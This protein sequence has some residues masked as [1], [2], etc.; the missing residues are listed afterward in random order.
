M[1]PW[2]ARPTAAAFFFA[3]GVA[4]VSVS[5]GDSAQSE[6]RYRLRVK[7]VDPQ[8]QGNSAVAIDFSGDGLLDIVCG[9]TGYLAPD[10]QKVSLYEVAWIGGRLDDYASL[11]YDVNGDGRTDLI[12]ANY[13]S[14]SIEW[15]EQADPL[16][17]EWRRHRV[18]SPGAMETGRLEDVDGDGRLDLVP[19]GRDFAAWWEIVADQVGSVRWLRHDWPTEA[20]GHGIGL[21]DINGDGRRDLVCPRGWFE[22]PADRRSGRWR[23]H[24]D[25]T[26]DADASI[27]ILVVDVDGD[28]DQDLIW[29]RGHAVGI[30]WLEQVQ[31]VEGSRVWRRHAIDTSWSQAHS[32]LW[33]DLD[34][35]GADELIAGKRY[36]G[37]DGRDPGEYDPLVAFGYRF[38]GQKR[39]WQRESIFE[40]VGAAFGLDPKAVDLDRDGDLDLILADRCGLHWVENLRFVAVEPDAAFRRTVSARAET[41]AETPS[42]SNRLSLAAVE[43]L[44]HRSV[45]AHLDPSG[46]VRPVTDLWEMGRRRRQILAGMERAMG[47]LPGPDRRVDLHVQVISAA[48]CGRY[49]RRRIQYSPEM[50]DRVPAY[51]LVPRNLTAAAPAMLCLHQTVAI[52]KDEPAGLG[53]RRTLRY[54]HEL[55]ERGYVCLVP[56]YPSFGEYPYDFTAAGDRHE[57][58][59][60]KAVWNNL[61]GVDLLE[62]VPEVDR[63][64]IGAIG[65]S[66]GGHNALFTAAFDLRIKAVVTS[67][68]FTAFHDYYQGKLAGWTSERY[69]PRIR[70][71]YGNDPNRVPFD[72]QEVLAAIAPRA[73][74]VNAPQHDENFEVRG[75]EKVMR[76]AEQVFG[77]Y[78]AKERLRVEYP[79]CDHEFP[80]EVRMEAYRFLDEVLSRKES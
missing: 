27:P 25:F 6:L 37:H 47:P 67:C 80:D 26:L 11:P 14:R 52:G 71:V 21:G 74:F 30:Y 13:R 73:V 57:S 49:V 5:A 3:A 72:F 58:G 64:R 33:A 65:H 56:D 23:H 29:G 42:D 35:D 32:L 45:L 8:S 61:R 78:H 1:K 46:Q 50:G 66:L 44:D 53:E 54:A 4:T 62:A 36:L 41:P 31:R 63:D 19:N 75:V 18:D 79:D 34:G 59:T 22:A 77:L 15:I 9:G 10:W 2:L 7:T 12:T 69:M 39:T 17:N 51:L 40:G 48:D 76:E 16:G 38:D 20:A 28:G 43:K 55:A 24:A 68:G 70:D 60:M